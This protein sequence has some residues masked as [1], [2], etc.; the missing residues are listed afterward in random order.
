MAH[1]FLPGGEGALL[2]AATLA[3]IFACAWLAS[4]DRRRIEG[5]TLTAAFAGAIGGSLIGV[6]VL[7]E[8]DFLRL[9][10]VSRQLMPEVW[11]GGA[12][13]SAALGAWLFARLRTSRR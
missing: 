2:L 10:L 3:A 9:W 8:V 4:P 11:A 5:A 6:L 1:A 12:A 13:L 7:I